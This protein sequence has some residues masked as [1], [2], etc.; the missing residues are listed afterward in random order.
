MRTASSD[1]RRPIGEGG[2]SHHQH[3]HHGQDHDHHHHGQG[4]DH[5]H[6]GQDHRYIMTKQDVRIASSD[7]QQT[8]RKGEWGRKIGGVIYQ[9]QKQINGLPEIIF[10]I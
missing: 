8:G 2:G 1:L 3:H 5:H 6:H 9:K 7:L 4:H 10:K